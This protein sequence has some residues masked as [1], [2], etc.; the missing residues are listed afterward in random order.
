MYK[1]PLY[2]QK[3]YEVIKERYNLKSNSQAGQKISY[4][5]KYFKNY[6]FWT[7]NPLTGIQ[8]LDDALKFTTGFRQFIG[9]RYPAQSYYLFIVKGDFIHFANDDIKLLYYIYNDFILP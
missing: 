2:K 5:K 3:L 9:F 6:I 8:Y 1:I 7:H 4:L